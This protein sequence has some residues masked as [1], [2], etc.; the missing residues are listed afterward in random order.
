MVD[1]ISDD[2]AEGG[3]LDK[4]DDNPLDSSAAIH[5]EV[6]QFCGLWK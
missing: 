4:Q 2:K 3:T 1:L 6:Q 5:L